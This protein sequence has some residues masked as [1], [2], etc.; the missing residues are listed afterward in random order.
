MNDVVFD[1]ESVVDL[2]GTRLDDGDEDDA[3]S[4][5]AE[6]GIEGIKRGDADGLAMSSID[7]TNTTPSHPARKAQPSYDLACAMDFGWS[8]TS[9]SASP[10][11]AEIL[12]SLH[13][14][15]RY[16]SPLCFLQVITDDVCVC[17]VC[18]DTWV[19]LRDR[20]R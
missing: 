16:A 5:V 4:G 12:T 19:R 1:W 8:G 7:S 3:A 14:N 9:F 6:A 13:R 2:L 17:D 10:S 15:I 20:H 18:S 11:Q